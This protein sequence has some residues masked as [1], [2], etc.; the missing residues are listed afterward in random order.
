MKKLTKYIMFVFALVMAVTVIGASD[1]S[2]ATK[3]TLLKGEK[4]YYIPDYLTVKSVKSSNKKVATVKKSGSYKVKITAKKKGTTTL[5]IKTKSYKKSYTYKV[6]LTVAKPS[7]KVKVVNLS[8]AYK[9]YNGTYGGTIVYSITNKSKVAID[10]LPI[11]YTLKNTAGTTFK[12]DYFSVY[13]VGKGQTAYET[14]SFY[15]SPKPLSAAKCSGKF[16]GVSYKSYNRSGITYKYTDTTKKVKVT[17]KKNSSYSYGTQVNLT[18]KNKYNKYAY[19]VVTVLGYDSNGKVIET[20]DRTFYL[21][22]KAT[23]SS[24]VTFSTDDVKSY[25]VKTRAYSYNRS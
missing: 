17:A 16:A 8:Q 24:Y 13:N 11:K 6:K 10:S 21:R 7:V 4:V 22:K 1:V 19:I 9:S 23:D 5:T 12:S 25:K 15:G 20:C 2:A 14:V 3:L 18:V